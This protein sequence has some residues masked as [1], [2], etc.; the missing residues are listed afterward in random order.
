[1]ERLLLI[2]LLLVLPRPLCALEEAEKR[3]LLLERNRRLEI[4]EVKPLSIAPQAIAPQ[5]AF[6]TGPPEGVTYHTLHWYDESARV[7]LW[8]SDDRLYLYAEPLTSQFFCCTTCFIVVQNG[9]PYADIELVTPTGDSLCEDLTDGVVVEFT[10]WNFSNGC[11]T[12]DEPFTVYYE[13][14]TKQSFPYIAYTGTPATPTGIQII[15]TSTNL[16][17]GVQVGETVQFTVNALA[18]VGETIHYQFFTRAGYGLDRATW[19]GNSWIM[20]QDWSAVNTVSVVFATPGIYFLAAHLE[21]A[22]EVWAFGDPQ[23]GI[24]VEVWP[25]Q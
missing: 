17:T 16:V 8:L 25:T 22:G 3:E 10:C 13:G 18:G 20:V 12:K 19:G 4:L 7:C 1:M 11:F 14:D 15:G 6:P 21:R 24:V 2:W 9:I 23:T 5:T